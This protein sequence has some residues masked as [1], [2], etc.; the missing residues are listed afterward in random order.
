MEKKKDK[1]SILYKKLTN[2]KLR[3]KKIG[4]AILGHFGYHSK[5][6]L[7]GLSETPLL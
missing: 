4:Q 7:L 1:S 2:M 5:G 3:E 6:C